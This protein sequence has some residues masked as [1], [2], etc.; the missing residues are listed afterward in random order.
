MSPLTRNKA[1][2]L[3]A[4]GK[5]FQ[6]P[7]QLGKKA[8]PDPP[9]VSKARAPR[10]GTKR[11][12]APSSKGGSQKGGTL[13]RSSSKQKKRN[14]A[15]GNKTAEKANA[16]E[17]AD[18]DGQVRSLATLPVTNAS[19]PPDRRT[20]MKG[21]FP[22]GLPNTD[23]NYFI[24]G[25]NSNVAGTSH[26]NSIEELTD[27]RLGTE[28]VVTHGPQEA[29]DEHIPGYSSHIAGTY[30]DLETEEAAGEGI[31][32]PDP[33]DTERLAIE[34]NSATAGEDRRS[35]ISGESQSDRSGTPTPSLKPLDQDELRANGGLECGAAAMPTLTNPI[36]DIWDHARHANWKFRQQ[37]SY[38]DQASG[39]DDFHKVDNGLS[40]GQEWRIID[41]LM[42][43]MRLASQ[44]L[45][46]PGYQKFWSTI[47]YAP[48]TFHKG[49]ELWVLAEEPVKMTQEVCNDM[50]ERLQDIVKK[51]HF[52][53]E[54]PQETWT[55]IRVISPNRPSDW[56]ENTYAPGYVTA[57]REQIMYAVWP[58]D[59]P[60]RFKR[61]RVHNTC[62]KL[63]CLFFVA[64]QLA[65]GLAKLLWLDRC[66]RE[67]GDE[68]ELSQRKPCMVVRGVRYSDLCVA[69]QEFVLSGRLEA[70]NRR[71]APIC[72][73]GLALKMQE[74]IATTEQGFE[75]GIVT[76]K[77]IN[78]RFTAEWW[79]QVGPEQETSGMP[80]VTAAGN[81]H[82]TLY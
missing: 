36:H 64:V 70:V 56:R 58:N 30:G 31:A 54:H 59:S 46:R 10:I 4:K 52:I 47:M 23:D 42:P 5:S 49:T 75:V 37:A 57:L 51:H 66:C 12:T 81:G 53:F 40:P 29:N 35:S 69:F 25:L 68:A 27:G 14:K 22:N 63:R 65:G 62:E 39:E 45:T 61:W 44:W 76:M 80:V 17:K 3:R 38:D 11:T 26:E 77:G 2:E 13:K 48:W 72:S 74:V 78:Q 9:R 18:K 24:H 15:V 71:Q 28:G 16:V 43:A 1:K 73:D 7:T 67:V 79:D 20:G 60:P 32:G 6:D 55:E 82:Y 21:L 34:S 33:N 41:T 19:S 8:P 50:E